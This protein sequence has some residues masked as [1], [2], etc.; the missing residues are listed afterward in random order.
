[1]RAFAPLQTQLQLFARS[2]PPHAP[3]PARLYAT[4]DRYQSSLHPVTALD[5]ARLVFLAHSARRQIDHRPL[6]FFCH[7]LRCLTNT[8]R[9][10]DSE[11]LE[12]FP[13]HPGFSQVLLH[14]RWIIQTPQRPLQTQ[15]IPTVQY[16]NNIALVTLNECLPYL[17]LHHIVSSV[18]SHDST[19]IMALLL[20]LWL[21]LCRA[22]PFA[23][24]SPVPNR[25]WL[26]LCRAMP[27][28]VF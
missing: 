11:L 12:V 6:L 27:Q 23:V 1:M 25:F 18:C 21:R 19:Y 28:E 14:Y 15:S 13:H 10:S 20:S 4:E 16:P 17:V 2:I 7:I 24:N 22:R 26:R 8:A 3:P 9:Q 5:L